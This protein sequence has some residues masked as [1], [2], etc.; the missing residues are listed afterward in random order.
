[1]ELSAKAGW[2]SDANARL[3]E[4]S[5]PNVRL[6]ERS[7]GRWSAALA[8]SGLDAAEGQGRAG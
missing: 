7:A 3:A 6:A 1:M 8:G 5:R 4:Q 2:V